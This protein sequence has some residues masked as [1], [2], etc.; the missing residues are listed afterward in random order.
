MLTVMICIPTSFAHS[1][2]LLPRNFSF[3]LTVTFALQDLSAQVHHN[4]TRHSTPLSSSSW[5][6]NKKMSELDLSNCRL[7]WRLMEQSWVISPPKPLP[8]FSFNEGYNCSLRRQLLLVFCCGK[9]QTTKSCCLQ[10][11]RFISGP[12]QSRVDCRLAAILFHLSSS[13]DTS[14]WNSPYLWCTFLVTEG[15]EQWWND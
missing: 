9:N 10:E 14:W 11:W 6:Q 2:L 12:H 8:F 5:E 1:Y 7:K 4:W 15:K 13:K 3:I